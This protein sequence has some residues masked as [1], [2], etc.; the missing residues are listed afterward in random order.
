MDAAEQTLITAEAHIAMLRAMQL[1]AIAFLD[2]GEGATAAG[3]RT[4]QGWVAVKGDVSPETARDLVQTAR[5]KEARPELREVFLEG[6]VSFD[7]VVAVSRTTADTFE[8]LF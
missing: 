7:R 5:G 3:A 8:P 4:L 1:A 6:E 2:R